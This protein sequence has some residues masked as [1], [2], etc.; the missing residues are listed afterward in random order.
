MIGR[1]EGGL[2]PAR[3]A[4]GLDRRQMELFALRT[5]ILP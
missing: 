5:G 4:A 1:A 2:E 3:E